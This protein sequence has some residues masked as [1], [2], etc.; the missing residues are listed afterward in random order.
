MFG[1]NDAEL[2]SYII[3]I[4]P[5]L[6]E[7]IDLPVQ[8]E[9]IAPIGQIIVNNERYKNAFINAINVIGL[10]MI[11]RN[12]WEDPWENFTNNGYMSFGDSA[13]ELAV[14][15][16]DVFDYNYYATDVDHF[17][18]NVVPN[19][20]EYIHPLNYQKFYKTTTSDTQLAMAFYNEGG[21]VSLI[22]EIISSLYE[23]YKYDKYIVNKYMLC[24]RILDGTVTSVQIANYS[25]LSARERVAAMKNIS[26]LMTF[27][28]PN[29]NPTGL[30]IATPFSKQIAIVNTDFEASLSTEVLA[31]SFF[32]NDAEMKSRMAL[33]DGFGNHDVARL[34]EVLGSQFVSFSSGELEAL[35]KIPACIID[36]E[37]FQN[38][39]YRLDGAAETDAQEVFTEGNRTGFKRTSFYNPE[40]MKN[41][42]WLHYWGIKSTS[43]FKQAVVFT[44]DS[45]GVTSVAISP[46]TASVF[47]GQDIDLKATVTTTGFA[48]KGVVWSVDSTSAAAGVTI[49]QYGKLHI[50]STVEANSE[51]TVTAK[52]VYN[53]S[54]YNTATIT[55]ASSTQPSVTSVTVSA[56]GSATTIAASATLQMSATVVRT[57][58]ASQ[59]VVWSLDA[60]SVADGFT[61]SSTGLVT[62]PAEPTVAKVTVTATSV[63]D[64]T[65]DDDYDLT[66]SS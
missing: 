38:K 1:R 46:S 28:N 40:T 6:R 36:D 47:A 64:D 39:T 49:N 50:P 31:T 37:W 41:N 66:V 3:N 18:D 11:D 51:I 32:R 44:L 21:L 61:I 12:Y 10:T 43:P 13:R 52:A 7:N 5:E 59:S 23:G 45:I 53:Q 55:V 57:G 16:A 48:N 42:H 62:A 4:E 33:V 29:Y 24:R 2:L 22:D 25:S 17:L 58:N 63:F 8:G 15:I 27:R 30:R 54:V 14:D 56:A 65:K 60:A 26:N 34:T 20:Y 35:A 19:V 9:S